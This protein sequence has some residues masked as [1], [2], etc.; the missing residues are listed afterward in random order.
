MADLLAHVLLA[1]ALFTA[2]GWW[3]TLPR[4]WVVV[5]M[6]GAALPDLTKVR[7]LV[8]GGAVESAVGVPFSFAPLTTLGGVLLTAGLVA[9]LFGRER[10][11]RAYG[12]LV[13]GGV[14]SL[15]VDALRITIDGRAGSVLYPLTWWEPPS[16]GFYLTSDPRVTAVAVGL[17][18]GVFLVDR[19]RSG[20]DVTGDAV[21]ADRG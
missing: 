21:A 15:V 12:F 8:N 13:A 20:G 16:L 14:T 4:R 7:L 10:R 11:R 2:V 5:A 17:A 6:G 18:L 9:L 19:R 1:Y 3:R